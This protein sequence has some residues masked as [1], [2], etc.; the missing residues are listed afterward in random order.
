MNPTLISYYTNDP[1]YR[2]CANNLRLSCEKLNIPIIIDN[3][4][5]L[6]SYWKNTLLKPS[7]ILNKLKELKKDLIWI[8]VDTRINEYPDCFKIWE[9]DILAASHTGDLHGIKASPIGIKYNDRSID[10]ITKWEKISRSKIESNDV[11]L[12]HDI[13]KYEL[14]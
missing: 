5:G 12:D 3:L 2:S 8:D 11:D 4:E 1:Y 6:G 10:L 9:C 13:L 14:L 7:Y